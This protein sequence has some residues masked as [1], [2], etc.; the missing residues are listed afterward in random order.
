MKYLLEIKI[1]LFQLILMG[2]YLVEML[3]F[4]LKQQMKSN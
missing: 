1:L 4:Q 3:I 2:L